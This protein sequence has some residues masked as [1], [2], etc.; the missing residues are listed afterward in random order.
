MIKKY[1]LPFTSNNKILWLI[2]GLCTVIFLTSAC[3][4]DQEEEKIPNNKV[5]LLKFDQETA[6]FTE[7]REYKYYAHPETFTVSLSRHTNGSNTITNIF[8]KERNALLLKTSSSTVPEEGKILIPEDFNPAVSF[9]RV[10]TS[11]YVTPA[12]GY[13]EITEHKLTNMQF[14]A[15]WSNVQSLAKVREYLKSNPKQQVQVFYFQPIS[16]NTYKSKWFFIL[17]N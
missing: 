16:D 7:G 3:H 2:T 17:K 11:D 4:W 12:N 14:L 8:Y 15:L 6:N 10:S 1:V 13:K 5:L 9:E